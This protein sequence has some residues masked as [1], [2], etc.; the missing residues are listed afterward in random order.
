MISL[1]KKLPIYIRIY[2]NKIAITN[3]KSDQTISK[4]S[5]IKFSST[6]LLVAEFNVAENLIRDILK[7]MGI[8][9]RNLKILIQQIDTFEDELSESEKRILRDLA[10]QA[11]GTEVYLAN[12]KKE[13]NKEEVNN[14]LITP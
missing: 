10:E 8:A 11:G 4:S 13:M 6:R 3:L 1:F 12:R 9:N 14:F 7:E 2:Y 5:V